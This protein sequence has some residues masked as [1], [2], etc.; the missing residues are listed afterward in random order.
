MRRAAIA[1]S[2]AA[3]LL[4]AAIV[5]LGPSGDGEQPAGDAP[6]VVARDPATI[7]RGAYLA[8][9]GN[10][11]DCHTPRGAPPYAG[12][13]GIPT[14]FG[15]VY[16][17]NLTPDRRTGIGDW[18]PAQFRRALHEGRS[19]DGR[20]LAPAFPYD[21]FTG[22]GAGDADALFAYLSSLPAVPQPNRPHE[23]RFPY[24]TQAALAVWRALYFR[25]GRFVP[26]PARSDA[27]NRGAYLVRAL[28][29]CSACH[30]A[31][32][33]LGA[34]VEPQALGG[35]LIA[36][37]Q[38]LAPALGG[39]TPAVAG[40]LKT[41]RSA[42]G[43]L[44]GPM[45]EVVLHSTQHLTDGD[46]AAMADFLAS[47]PRP[48]PSA[49]LAQAPTNGGQITKGAGLYRDRCASCHGDDGHGRPGVYAALDGNATVLAEPPVNFAQVVLGGAFA[50]STAGNPRPFGMPPFAIEF[51]DD[52]VAA[53]LSYV[54]GAWSN[55]AGPVETRLVE[56]WRSSVRP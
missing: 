6:P 32:N 21:S 9:A 14:P 53:V 34:T 47:V 8:R 12:G 45:A 17:T 29:H 22:I 5:E 25:P 7:A 11:Q 48:R 39:A 1:G 10:C 51:S 55:R 28:G 23:L 33:R 18:T 36:L 54:R 50:P 56:R 30:A 35:G 24:G 40:L 15:T 26:D 43:A 52:E 16:S 20:L 31:R 3:L 44:L 42:D 27:W 2:A 38:W 13:R 37:Q 46:L 49:P 41:G 4:V 19:R